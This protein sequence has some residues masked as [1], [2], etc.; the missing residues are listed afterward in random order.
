MGFWLIFVGFCG[1]LGV[2]VLGFFEQS[3]VSLDTWGTGG[4]S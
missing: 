4:E 2:K 1:L 3:E